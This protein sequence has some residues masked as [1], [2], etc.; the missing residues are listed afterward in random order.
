MARRA[1]APGRGHTDH[2][3]G[4][5]GNLGRHGGCG[6][7]D[8]LLRHQPQPEA[9]RRLFSVRVNTVAEET[10][11][12]LIAE[13][14]QGYAQM[15]FKKAILMSGHFENEHYNAI[16]AGIEKAADAIQ[17]YFMMPPQFCEDLIEELDSVEET[18]P[19]CQRPRSRMGNLH[20]AALLPGNGGYEQRHRRPSSCPCRVFQHIFASATRAGHRP[21][22]VRSWWMRSFP[23]GSRRS[24][25]CWRSKDF[26][27]A[28]MRDLQKTMR[29]FLKKK[30]CLPGLLY[31]QIIFKVMLRH[32]VKLRE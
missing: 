31:T 25:R 23:T 16:M 27:H 15:G 4:L 8:A 29:F 20:D 7:A 24:T 9:R 12:S 30:A 26:Y 3:G 19:L 14:L 21:N 2:R 1:P 10:L 11:S 22:T 32:P 13:L 6:R 18:W 28:R 5:S 17:G